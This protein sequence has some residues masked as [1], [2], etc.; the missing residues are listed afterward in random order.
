M[1]QRLGHLIPMLPK[2]QLTGRGQE[3]P[4]TGD[5]SLSLDHLAQALNCSKRHL[6]NAFSA[7][8][9]TPAH[10]IQRQRIQA[11]LARTTRPPTPV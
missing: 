11:R 10:D 7:E 1:T 4:Q 8:D 9:D 2:E 3:L 6:H 5:P